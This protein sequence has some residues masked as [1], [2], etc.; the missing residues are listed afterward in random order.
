MLLSIFVDEWNYF[1]I[2][3]LS[4]F[5]EKTF[6][7]D[8]FSLGLTT[9]AIVGGAALG[10][11][12][13][14]WLTD[15]FGRRR[16]FMGNMIF[17]ILSA[18]GSV[19][20]P[21]LYTFII[22]R[23][24]TGIP[25]GSDLANGYSYL[26]DGLPPGSR[27]VT[28]AKNTLMASLA[29]VSINIIVLFLL[30]IHAPYTIIWKAS[31][32]VS[33]IPSVLAIVLAGNLPE[34]GVWKAHISGRDNSMSFRDAMNAIRKDQII[35]R[36]SLF[37]WISG[38]ASTVEVGT[39]AFFIPLIISTSGISSIVQSRIVIILVYSVGI[40]AGIFGPM[41]LYRTGL[42]KLSYTGYFL[43]ILAI[44]GSGL[45][46]LFSLD[47]LVPLFVVFFVWGNHW[48]SQPIL[49]SQALIANAGVRGK[50]TGLANFISLVPTFITT[51]LF[52]AVVHRVGLGFA[53][54][55]VVAAPVVGIFTSILI[56][57]EVFGY[58]GD[59]QE[60]EKEVAAQLTDSV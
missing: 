43:T 12:A 25:V 16:V 10:S 2:P 30:I 14:G 40:P 38:V 22:L 19:L 44:L 59:L 33:I 49:T 53:T 31:I 17:F 52:P 36:T 3:M 4:L 54:L 34:S 56:F 9:S 5:V 57:R 35:K 26:M 37:A 51:S 28:G 46:L 23:F 18:A 39:F 27:E 29:I 20:A 21:N 6:N 55:A 58:S 8:S 32:A 60:N 41:M 24:L 48:N 42:R 13:G 50:L 7:F 45:S 11:I 47:Y 15:R 1:S